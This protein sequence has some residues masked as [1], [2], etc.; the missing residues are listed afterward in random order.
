[1]L[2]N[3]QPVLSAVNFVMACIPACAIVVYIMSH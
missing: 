3:F 2:N 1:M